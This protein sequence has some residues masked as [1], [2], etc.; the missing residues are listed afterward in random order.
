M[1]AQDRRELRKITYQ[2]VEA[3]ERGVL[4]RNLLSKGVGFR[5]EEEFW[6]KEKLKLKGGKEFDKKK[7]IVNLAMKEKLQDNYKHLVKLKKLRTKLAGRIENKVGMTTMR[8]IRSDI[9]NGTK[10]IRHRTKEKYK[11]KEKFL[12]RKYGRK[13]CDGMD[14]LAGL[15]KVDRLKYEG[16]KIFDPEHKW[17]TEAAKPPSIVCSGTNEV[18]LNEDE[19]NWLKLGPKF[20]SGHLSEELF[21]VE[22]EIGK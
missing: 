6:K 7:G 19:M 18:T 22:L 9:K 8:K 17:V 3:E 20:S 14:G 12:V 10:V 2:V 5:E 11:N 15:D 21:E 13:L 1:T 4:I 16:A